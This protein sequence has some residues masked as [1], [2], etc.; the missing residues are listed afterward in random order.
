MCGEED[1]W[2]VVVS[3]SVIVVEEREENGTVSVYGLRLARDT[4]EEELWRPEG[5]RVDGQI[6][7][8]ADPVTGR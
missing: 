1:W 8:P 6:R 4:V 7:G 3:G 2:D 5:V